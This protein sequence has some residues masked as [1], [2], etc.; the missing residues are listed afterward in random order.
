MRVLCG[1]GGAI[2]F[3]LQRCKSWSFKQAEAGYGA[4]QLCRGGRF[5]A[6]F[7]MSSFLQLQIKGYLTGC[8]RKI[9][10]LGDI[11]IVIRVYSMEQA[12]YRVSYL[13]HLAPCYT[14]R[15]PSGMYIWRLNDACIKARARLCL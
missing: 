14:F 13:S 11:P 8:Y 12:G 1:Y 3:D 9:L 7:L 10:C 2:A 6:D 4:Q 5:G 15:L